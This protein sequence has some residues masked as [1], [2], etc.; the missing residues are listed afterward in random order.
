MTSTGPPWNPRN[1][2]N[3]LCT[4]S[5]SP[6]TTPRCRSALFR[7]AGVN[8]KN[9]R[10]Y[11]RTSCLS[12]RFTPGGSAL[13]ATVVRRVVIAEVTSARC[14]RESRAPWC[15]PG[16]SDMLSRDRTRDAPCR[17]STSCDKPIQRTEGAQRGESNKVEPRHT[18]F[19]PVAQARNR[20]VCLDF[21]PERWMNDRQ[22]VDIY[23]VSSCQEDVICALLRAVRDR[24]RN[25]PICHLQFGH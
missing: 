5:T 24:H 2:S 8:A 14:V 4:I 15:P 25:F 19:E 21:G 18:A 13:E 3:A 20:P 7:S 17:R 6:G 12:R 23:R 9:I 16:R 10:W 11:A 22:L 1:L